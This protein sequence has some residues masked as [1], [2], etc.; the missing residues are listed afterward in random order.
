MARAPR[1]TLPS[2]GCFHAFARGVAAGGPLFRDDEDRATFIRLAEDARRRNAW[3]LHAYCLM[4]S[5]YHLVVECTREGLSRG[6]GRLNG[7]Y[8][9]HF[10]LRHGRFGHV[11][12]GR[13]SARLIEDETYLFDACAYVLLNP[14]RAGL[15]ERA[16]DWRWSYSASDTEIR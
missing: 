1:R 15:C 11:F 16:R 3:T 10:N 2:D 9:Q 6:L 5:H 12:A 14:V 13:F 7:L 4:G 8:A